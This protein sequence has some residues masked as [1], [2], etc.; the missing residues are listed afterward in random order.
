MKTFTQKELVH[1]SIT[2]IRDYKRIYDKTDDYKDKAL[3]F[4]HCIDVINS[5][6]DL[7]IMSLNDYWLLRDIVNRM[8][9]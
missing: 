3:F 4:N 2:L 5:L 6:L 8:F 9:R 7:K 1:N